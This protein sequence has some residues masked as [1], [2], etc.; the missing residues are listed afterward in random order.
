VIFPS[1]AQHH[2]FWAYNLILAVAL[3][4]QTVVA[5]RV[6]GDQLGEERPL[7][8]VGAPARDYFGTHRVADVKM[9]SSYDFHPYV[10]W[11]LDVPVDVALSAAATERQLSAG[12]IRAHRKR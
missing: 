12:R 4:G 11:Y 3:A 1:G 5:F 6:A 10:S 9:V 8:S 7:N 2:A